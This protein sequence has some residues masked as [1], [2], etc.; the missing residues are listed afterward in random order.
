MK[1]ISIIEAHQSRA[2]TALSALVTAQRRGMS[3]SAGFGKGTPVTMPALSPTMAHGKI[4]RWNKKEGEA[5][6]SGDVLVRMT[7]VVA[8]A[9][10]RRTARG[11]FY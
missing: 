1:P 4:A 8:V 9:H 2:C 10:P 11:R 3:T 6:N 5:V 7:S